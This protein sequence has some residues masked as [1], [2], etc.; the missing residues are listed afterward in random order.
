MVAQ[1]FIS[2]GFQLPLPL[3]VLLIGGLASPIV[4]LLAERAGMRRLREAWMVLVAAGALGSVYLLYQQLAA[5]AGGVMVVAVWG[6]TPP[7]AGC[8]EIDMLSVF[9]SGS[10]ALRRITWGIVRMA[11]WIPS[12][13]VVFSVTSQPS[14]SNCWR[15]SFRLFGW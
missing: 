9:M 5:T 12:S 1:E 3:T 13:P 8:F 10:I 15:N 6:Q 7:L 4:G 2:Q 11:V 14:S